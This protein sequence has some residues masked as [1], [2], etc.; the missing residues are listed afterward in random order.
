MST[1][2]D[3]ALSGRREAGRR[4]PASQAQ[5]PE[6]DPESSWG[7]RDPR[8]DPRS[9]L[10]VHLLKPLNKDPQARSD[11][12]ADRHGLG[13]LWARQGHARDL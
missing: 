6:I 2:G 12:D 11:T 7:R 8:G 3:A 13:G 9:C 10:E 5:T 1:V 4:R